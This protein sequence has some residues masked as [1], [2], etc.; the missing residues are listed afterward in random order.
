MRQHVTRAAALVLVASV[1]SA[2][3]A[4]KESK[5][6][7]KPKAEDVKPIDM[8]PQA[9][10]LGGYK[11][12]VGNYYVA[13]LPGKIDDTRENLQWFFVGDGK[14]MYQQRVISSSLKP[15]GIDWSVWSPRA[16]DMRAALVSMKSD[17]MYVACRLAT[18]AGGRRALTALSADELKTLLAKAKFVPMPH[19]RIPHFLARDDDANYYYVDQIPWELGGNGY[20]VYVG[21]TGAMKQMA[22]SNMA[23]DSVG[24]IYATKAGK[25]KVS[26]DKN[27]NIVGAAWITKGQKTELTIVPVDDNR[28][29]V[30]RE[31]GIYGSLNIVCDDQ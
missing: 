16:K 31:L 8:T 12:E 18:V 20:H 5:P 22:L 14:T 28:Y 10:N 17:G 7:P 15:T 19:L 25:L 4:K 24:E 30:Y 3:P 1:A 29:L 9:E 21:Q 26:L 13:P 23:S 27:S 2:A 11:D 6:D